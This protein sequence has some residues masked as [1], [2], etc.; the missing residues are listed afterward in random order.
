VAML[1]LLLQSRADVQ[2]NGN[3]KLYLLELWTT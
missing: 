2:W 1:R 3:G